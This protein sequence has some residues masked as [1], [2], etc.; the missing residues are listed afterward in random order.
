VC[1]GSTDFN[2]PVMEKVTNS[3]SSNSQSEQ[4]THITATNTQTLLRKQ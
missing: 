1:G 2:N 4:T 3:L